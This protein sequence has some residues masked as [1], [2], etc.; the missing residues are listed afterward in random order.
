MDAMGQVPIFLEACNVPLERGVTIHGPGASSLRRW[1]M[2]DQPIG[3]D[4]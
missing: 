2:L 1:E 3:G 4:S